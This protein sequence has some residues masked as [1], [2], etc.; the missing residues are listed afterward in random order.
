MSNKYDELMVDYIDPPTSES[1]PDFVMRIGWSCPSI[2]FG[3]VDFLWQ[4]NELHVYTEHMDRAFLK[5]LMNL[6][7]EKVVIDG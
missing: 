7:V 3:T 5:R 6:V 1:L 2:G 4:N